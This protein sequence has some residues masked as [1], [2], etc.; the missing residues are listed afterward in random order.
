[1]EFVEGKK[2]L[3]GELA[4]GEGMALVETGIQC[5]LSQLFETGVMHAD[6]HGGNLLKVQTELPVAPCV[7][8]AW[9]G[10]ATPPN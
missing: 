4:E 10:A 6:P 5:T 8:Q 1:M 7:R 2:L 3:D 9:R